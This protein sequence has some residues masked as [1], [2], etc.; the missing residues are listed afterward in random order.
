MMDR[1]AFVTGLGT[2]FAAPRAVEAQQAEKRYRIG[3]LI[4]YPYD[5]TRAISRVFV[6]ALQDLGY[7]EGRNLQIEVRSAH[8]HP[9]RLPRLAAELVRLNVDVMVTGGDSEVRAAKEATPKIPIVMAPSGDPVRAG[10][11]ATYAR[12]G[13]NVTGLSWM[14]PELSA[15]LLQLV[16]ELLPNA[17]RLAV[18]WNSANPVKALDFEETRRAAEAFGL[19]ATSVALPAGSKLETAFAAIRQVRVD[20][21]V[22]LTDET[23]SGAVYPQ[24]VDFATQQRLPSILGESSYA[25]AGGLIGFGPSGREM[26]RRA[27]HYVDKILRG[28]KPADLPVEQ[29]TTFELVINMKTA[30]ALGL[31][32]PP[33]L[34]LRADQVI[35]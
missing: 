22:I 30:K 23:L 29:P 31:T 10:Y 15:K 5:P 25:V 19:N 12:P 8:H 4:N 3:L 6:P 33:S 13:G 35:E 18:L 17:S 21:L 20:A 14:S 27:A 7:I 2:L 16:K 1:R 34:L 28:A 24:I 26:W 11:V 32:I 9:E